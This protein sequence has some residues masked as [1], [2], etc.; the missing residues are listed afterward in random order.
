MLSLVCL[1]FEF[2]VVQIFYIRIM[3]YNAVK[4]EKN[5]LRKPEIFRQGFGDFLSIPLPGA[6]SQSMHKQC[7]IGFLA[8]I[9][10]IKTNQIDIATAESVRSFQVMHVFFV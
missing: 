2:Y 4:F 8:M 6:F 7:E 10:I 9:P 1:I 3:Q 5:Y